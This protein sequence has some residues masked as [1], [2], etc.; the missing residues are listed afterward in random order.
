MSL[1]ED[2]ALK[3]KILNPEETEMS[4]G[5]VPNVTFQLE[6]LGVIQGLQH[7]V[8]NLTST[9]DALVA[10]VKTLANNAK[11]LSTNVAASAAKTTPQVSI[12][13]RPQTKSYVEAAAQPPKTPAK[14]RKRSGTPGPTPPK[15]PKQKLTKEARAPE[16]TSAKPAKS[17]IE[18]ATV[19]RPKNTTIAKRQIYATRATPAPLPQAPKL[20][21]K[22]SMAITK[23]LQKCGCSAP[24]NLQIQINPTNGTLSLSTAPGTEA[25]EYTNYLAPMTTALSATLPEAATD[26]KEFK[27]APTDTQVLIHGISL[28]ATSNE[29]DSLYTV[30]KESLFLGQQINISSARFLQKDPKIKERKRYTSVVVSLPTDDVEKITPAV[31]VLGRHESSAVMWHSNPIKQC[32]KCYLYGHPKEG[33]TA[34]KHTCPMCA[35]EHRLKEHKCVSPTCPKK[36][37]KKIVVNW[38]PVTPSKCITC[39]GGTTQHMPLNA[40]SRLRQWLMLKLI[41]TEGDL[42]K[43][44]TIW[45]LRTNDGRI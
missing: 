34:T 27:R 19:S 37:N 39:G 26:H 36:G 21:P 20:E 6:V 41:M 25:D 5:K 4:D 9:V 12:L 33:C 30:M 7:Q 14:G 13:Q 17:N 35:G 2:S 1:P 29:E 22:I 8:V 43:L 44:L 40:R 18:N 10:T 3:E 16:D 24:T 45:I 32:Q 31:L 28:E 23:E 38:C 11:D 42:P 15:N